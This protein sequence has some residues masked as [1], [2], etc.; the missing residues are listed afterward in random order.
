MRRKQQGTSKTELPKQIWMLVTPFKNLQR[1][2]C[3]IVHSSFTNTCVGYSHTN[4][5]LDKLHVCQRKVTDKS[6]LWKLNPK[7]IPWH[8]S[9]LVLYIWIWKFG[10]LHTTCDKLRSTTDLQRLHTR[11]RSNRNQQ[12]AW[13]NEPECF[14]IA[15]D[16]HFLRT[17][18]TRPWQQGWWCSVFLQFAS[19][20]TTE[21]VYFQQQK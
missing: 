5:K 3:C 12:F 19:S 21:L 18:S 4:C 15:V 6:K 17:T 8:C 20:H 16:A 13:S 14:K 2:D 7:V 9:Y 1:N 11:N 10:L